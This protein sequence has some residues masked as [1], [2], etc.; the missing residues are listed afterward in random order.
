MSANVSHRAGSKNSTGNPGD[1]EVT[2]YGKRTYAALE[3]EPSDLLIGPSGS[4]KGGPY[5][6]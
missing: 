1:H 6:R 5:A 3:G 4:I 2:D